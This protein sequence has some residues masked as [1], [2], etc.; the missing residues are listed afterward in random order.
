MQKLIE[1][2]LRL[3]IPGGSG[4]HAHQMKIKSMP[5]FLK[6]FHKELVAVEGR[7]GAGRGRL[8]RWAFETHEQEHRMS[9]REE[10]RT[11]KVVVLVGEEIITCI[12]WFGVWRRG[13]EVRIIA[14]VPSQ[15]YGS[16]LIDKAAYWR[17]GGLLLAGSEEAVYRGVVWS[18]ALL[19]LLYGKHLSFDVSLPLS[20]FLLILAPPCFS[21][22]ILSFIAAWHISRPA[23]RYLTEHQQRMFCLAVKVLN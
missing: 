11:D 7:G 12:L 3:L 16:T 2:V 5:L 14:S 13:G 17:G 19:T 1:F 21:A 8:K 10:E 6:S 20:C 22:L 23:S 9:W 4:K 15:Y 18:E